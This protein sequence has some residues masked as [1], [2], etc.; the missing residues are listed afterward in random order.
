M[1]SLMKFQGKKNKKE[2]QVDFKNK[3]RKSITRQTYGTTEETPS[4]SICY[5]SLPLK[6]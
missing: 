2:F 4:L 1:F 5:S 6:A 3:T